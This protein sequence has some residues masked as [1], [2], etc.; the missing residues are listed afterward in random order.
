MSSLA[1]ILGGAGGGNFV[2]GSIVRLL[3]DANQ[4]QSGLKTSEARMHSFGRRMDTIGRGM[5]R[6]G[7][8]WTR[9]VSAPILV[10]AGVA[11]KM[12]IDFET[13]FTK[14]RANSN[15]TSTQIDELRKHVL[16]L[17]GRTAK[18]PQE[19]AEG[20]YFLASAGLKAN[21][22]QQTLTASAKASAA[23][24]GE[25]SDIARL[26]AAALKAYERDGLKAA[27]VTDVL[28]AAV[29]EGSA[30]PEEF[31]NAMGRIL[32]T[33]Q[34]AGIGFGE[35]TASLASLSTVGVDVNEGVTAMRG[36]L[37]AL[38]SPGTQAKDTL[39]SLGLTAD[40]VRK[41]LSE[42]GLIDTMRLLEK[43]T[44]GNIDTM[45]KII[46][47]TRALAGVFSLT[48]QEAKGV[49]DSFRAVVGATG[50]LDRAFAITKK[51]TGFQMKQTMEEL[52]VEM[53]KVGKILLP[54]LR[55]VARYVRDMVKSFSELPDP[56]KKNIV[57]LGLWA[58]ALGPVL[59]ILGNIVRLSSLLPKKLPVP[60]ATPVPTGGAPTVPPAAGGA[61]GGA[62]A[63]AAGVGLLG[64]ALIAAGV[65]GG[66][67]G[68]KEWI[69]AAK[70]GKQAGEAMEDFALG[71]NELVEAMEGA[72]GVKAAVWRAQA[73]A[74]KNFSGGLALVGDTGR[75]YVTVMD[76]VEG[77]NKKQKRRIMAMV[78]SFGDYNIEVDESTFQ[79]ANNLAKVGDVEGAMKLLREALRDGIREQGGF[80]GKTDGSTSS[81]DLQR[82]RTE[83]LTTRTKALRDALNGIPRRVHTT[84]I[85]DTSQSEAAIR[86]L[87]AMLNNPRF[88][89]S[90][91]TNY[92]GMT[93]VGGVSRSQPTSR[94][95]QDS[96]RHTTTVVKVDGKSIAKTVSNH[97]RSNEILLG[98]RS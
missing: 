43:A 90:G 59:S 85:A 35:V 30:E 36:V 32:S 89:D 51:D 8:A 61:A 6:F 23:G 81:L 24:F 62:A 66:A 96:P 64:P 50:D 94:G 22:V 65:A 37:L 86:N 70:G 88:I 84:I 98:G 63:G 13:A 27:K 12:A 82:A 69:D 78:S 26:T 91:P 92:P 39:E 17:A 5:T 73:E 10:G 68:L 97:S 41:S 38:L 28:A 47:N 14:I 25:V 45:K 21:Q 1:G 33:A 74:V 80:K 16:D 77:V 58:A 9:S 19:L 76:D 53:I 29:R 34:K 55:D 93:D 87:L 54:V 44:G 40:Q 52:R 83:V 67:L 4:F 71:T 72:E 56:I 18:S 7:A 79:L 57:A 42:R 75:R 31:A 11:A 20:L 15:L 46:P 48:G 60:T 95:R 2:G 3:L 49:N